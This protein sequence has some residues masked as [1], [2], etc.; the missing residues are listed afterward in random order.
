[1]IQIFLRVK[2]AQPSSDASNKYGFL[3]VLNDYE[4]LLESPEDSHAY[5]VS[6]S[7]TL[8]KASFTKVFPP[9]CTQLDVFSTICA[10]LI[11]DSL[12]NMNDTLL[13]TLGVSGAGKTYTLFGP[14]DRPGVAF[15]ALDALFY[16][17]KGR[18]ASPQ[19]VEFL[20]SQLE[21]CKI[22]E[23]SKFL[24]G[25][26]PLD[27]K[28]P[29]TEYYASH[30]PKI[31]EKNYQYAIYLSFAE[32][33]N[34]RIFDLLEKASFFGH[35]H[36][37]SLKKSSTSD[38]KSI[39]G[40]QKVFVSNTTE[41]YK[42]IQKV[43]Q[44]RKS[45]STKSNSVSSRSHLIMSIELFKVCTKSNKFE[46][47]QIDLVDLA[48]SERTRSAET[49]GLLL[50]EGA[51]INRS[52]LTL[53]QC[54][55]ALRRKHEGKQHIIP[56]R[57]SKLTE[58]LFHSGHLS[59]LAGINMLVNIDPFGS[60]DENAQ[61]MRYSANAREILPPPLNENSGSQSPSHSLLQ[62]SKNTSSTKALTS[63]LEQLQ[64]ENQQLRMLLADADSE[65]MNLEYEIRQQMTREME[66]RVSEVERTFLTKLLEETAQGIEYTDQKLEKMGGWM[67]KLQDENSEKTETIAQLEQ[68]I[69][70]LHEE[71]RSLEEESIKESS[72]TQQNENQ[73]K[74]SSRKLLYEDKQA[75]QEAHT[76]NTKRKL[77]PQSTLIQAPN[78]DDEENV[79]SPSPKKKVVSPIKPLSPSRRPPLTSLY[80]G[81]TDID[82][83]EL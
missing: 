70:E 79:P 61:V 68:I 9:S 80:S 63:H 30:F 13:F 12:V 64:Q 8:E 29:N 82:I 10:P 35:R 2:K 55:E 83:N 44:L 47:C 20:R 21:K 31:E 77:W 45:T 3:T 53:G 49:S 58:L 14:S 38:K 26:A 74:R 78:S 76:I 19:T 22:V 18:E 42:L 71:L 50:R 6:K 11:A 46:S 37:L 25:E 39:A 36:A 60:F 75:I 81:T 43:L 59:G 41:A 15:L 52:L 1:M 66:E 57:Q 56:F 7:K 16:A 69:E 72:A 40:I 27:I 54:L 34:D 23:A 28:V 17:I 24:R 65:M 62:K 48:G 5:R 32:I 73:H 4:I 51:S 67:K 33:Y